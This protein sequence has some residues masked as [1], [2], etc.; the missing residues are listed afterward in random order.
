METIDHGVFLGKRI[1]YR[2]RTSVFDYLNQ[3]PIESH[4]HNMYELLFLKQGHILYTVNGKSYDLKKN[5]LILTRTGDLHCI[6]FHDSVYE[7]YDIVFDETYLSKNIVN[8]ISKDIDVVNF[9]GNKLVEQLFNKIDFYCEHFTG[10]VLERIIRN[11][12]EEILCNIYLSKKNMDIDNDIVKN[13]IEYI[14]NNLTSPID[15]NLLCNEF[16]ISKSYLH[17]QFIKYLQI[18]PKKYI[19]TKRL[20]RA[21][22]AI[23]TGAR[24]TDVFSECGFLDYSGFYREYKKYFGL[25]PSEDRKCN[26]DP[27]VLS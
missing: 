1:I 22:Y 11:I 13:I 14:D 4:C 20:I 27:V 7:R 8:I 6:K 2:H 16:F 23:K 3:S 9:E 5:S 26:I 18:S 24:P 19:I 17:K 10:M 21:R 15:L 12:V 25:S